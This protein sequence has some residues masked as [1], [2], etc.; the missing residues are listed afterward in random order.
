MELRLEISERGGD[1]VISA[2][3]LT[4]AIGDRT[5]VRDFSATAN[6]GDVIALVGPNGAGKTT[7]IQTLIGEREAQ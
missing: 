1:R 3:A 6:R 2:E 4:I 7:L 5:L